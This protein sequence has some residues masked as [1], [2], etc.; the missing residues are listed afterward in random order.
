MTTKSFS[1]LV[2]LLVVV[3]L[4]EAR[5]S[6][7]KLKTAN[8]AISS[9][10]CMGHGQIVWSPAFYPTRGGLNCRDCHEKQVRLDTHAAV[11]REDKSIDGFVF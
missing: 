11:F 10:Y 9:K 2:L 3:V 1:M 6:M 8:P 4:Q 7:R 5:L